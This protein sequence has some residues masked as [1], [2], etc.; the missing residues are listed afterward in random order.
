MNLSIYDICFDR[1]QNLLDEIMI[2]QLS[3]IG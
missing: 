3:H 1:E 2:T